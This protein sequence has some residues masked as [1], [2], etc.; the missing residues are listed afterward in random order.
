[1]DYENYTQYKKKREEFKKAF[2]DALNPGNKDQLINILMMNHRMKNAFE[3]DQYIKFD[4]KNGKSML[5]V[6]ANRM[7]MM[8]AACELLYASGEFK[9]FIPDLITI[10]ELRYFD[11][12]KTDRY[13]NDFN[14]EE[15]K[16]VYKE[17]LRKDPEDRE[18]LKELLKNKTEN[19]ER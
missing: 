19:I 4:I 12:I 7:A 2:D 6:H 1:M 17:L 13:H 16:E 18:K 11:V 8:L 15:E 10:L 3:K 5:D 9:D 14:S